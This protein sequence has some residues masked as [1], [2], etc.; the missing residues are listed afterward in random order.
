[1]VLYLIIFGFILGLEYGAEWEQKQ[2]SNYYK[3]K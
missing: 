3:K 1:M 2:N